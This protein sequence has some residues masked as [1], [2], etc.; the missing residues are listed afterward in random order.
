MIYV[1]ILC[2]S[3]LLC[4]VWG[5]VRL[6][7]G[8]DRGSDR[9]RERETVILEILMWILIPFI[10]I[11]GIIF[12]LGTLLAERLLY[13]SSVGY[14]LLLAWGLHYFLSLF[15]TSSKQRTDMTNNTSKPRK[16]Q[17]IT[18][19]YL[20]SCIPII[21]TY[22][23]LTR[24]YNKVWYDDSSLFHH[25]VSI[26][27][28][29]AKSNLQ[30]SKL[31]SNSGDYV[32][33]LFYLERAKEIDPDFCDTGYQEAL[34][35]IGIAQQRVGLTP[36]KQS[37]NGWKTNP[38]RYSSV[39]SNT[40]PTTTTTTTTLT[41]TPPSE[42]DYL[43]YFDAIDKAID[44]SLNNLQCIFT[45][46]QSLQLLQQ[47]WDFQT[48]HASQR[49]EPRKAMLRTLIKQAKQAQKGQLSLLASRKYSEASSIAFEMSMYEAAV[50]LVDKAEECLKPHLQTLS[51]DLLSS[52]T[53]SLETSS[54][55]LLNCRIQTLSGTMRSTLAETVAAIDA[56][57]EKEKNNKALKEKKENE[58]NKQIVDAKDLMKVAVNNLGESNVISRGIVLRKLMQAVN[59]TCIE[60]TLSL[61][62]PSPAF[63]NA[64]DHVKIAAIHAAKWQAKTFKLTDS[65]KASYYTRTMLLSFLSLIDS[66]TMNTGTTGSP[67]LLPE[68]NNELAPLRAQAYGIWSY[69][70][71]ASY[72]TKDFAVSAKYYC[73]AISLATIND[74][75]ILMH[76]IA[77]MD[78]SLKSISKH[79]EFWQLIPMMKTKSLISVGKSAGNNQ[80]KDDPMELC[81]Q[82]Y[83]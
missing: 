64:L 17:F 45:N 11:T 65:L 44:I 6:L 22:I 14:C 30:T 12:T 29:S 62:R 75:T 51:I 34:V 46:K 52:S 13:V 27:P 28:T 35:T 42:E 25:A 31:Y 20:L 15:T 82:Y 26:C 47:L 61:P 73:L 33:A 19:L 59:T 9:G 79:A 23:T 48:S 56:E 83:L 37:G 63:T 71:K 41:T 55:L 67:L 40:N 5:I 78:L 81:A 8:R 1:S 4:I 77:K 53:H 3:L 16:S 66:T 49:I 32:T 69:L 24:N 72:M 7:L 68:G 2:L 54:A 57:K 76:A 43:A 18:Y 80:N 38:N 39:E 36:P 74:M 10:P 70:A 21:A 58:N 60:L 50:R